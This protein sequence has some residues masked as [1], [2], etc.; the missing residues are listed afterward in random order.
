MLARAR[1][2]VEKIVQRHAVN[3]E[4][5]HLVRPGDFL[6]VSPA[7]VMTHDNTAAVMEKCAY[8]TGPARLITAFSC[9]V[10]FFL[11]NAGL[12]S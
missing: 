12:R 7:Y 8:Q 1:N 10:Y 9:A 4:Q 5:G 2:L 6:S 3:L 11:P